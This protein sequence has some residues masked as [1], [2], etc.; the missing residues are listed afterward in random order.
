MA[1]RIRT[2]E[3]ADLA[4]TR[5]LSVAAFNTG[6]IGTFID[7]LRSCDGLLGEWLAE[8]ESGALGYIAFTR[9]WVECQ[10]GSRIDAVQLAPLA[11][12]PGR[13]REG[14][15]SR[16]TLETIGLLKQR[17]E[18]LFLVV[19]H[20]SFYGRFGFRMVAAGEI[21]S[22]WTGKPSFMRRGEVVS[23]G[24]LVLPDVIANAP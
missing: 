6:D 24:R 2:I 10:D 4:P 9:V 18:R 19:G 7:N 23:R 20:T 17:G 5:N 16:L 8:D 12:R 13:Q 1:L 21:D 15:G 14:I 3:R 11:V 22:P